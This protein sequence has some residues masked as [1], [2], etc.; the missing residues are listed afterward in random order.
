MFQ[1]EC[2]ALTTTTISV[3][4]PTVFASLAWSGAHLL[5]DITSLVQWSDYGL[6]ASGPTTAAEGGAKCGPNTATPYLYTT[7]ASL[8]VQVTDCRAGSACGTQA[9]AQATLHILVFLEGEVPSHATSGWDQWACITKMAVQLEKNFGGL[10]ACHK[11]KFQQA[12]CSALNKI[13]HNYK[14]CEKVSTT[15]TITSPTYLHLMYLY[16]MYL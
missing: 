16:F 5:S 6:K 4:G 15:W 7:G 9:R 14:T 13:L 3:F 10:L 8:A 2:I 11:A 12:S 1:D